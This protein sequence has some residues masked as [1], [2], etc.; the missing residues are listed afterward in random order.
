MST[1]RLQISR[2]LQSSRRSR[3]PYQV[4]KQGMAVRRAV[5][6]S[7]GLSPHPSRR[8]LPFPTRST[9]LP[10]NS[11]A[12][13]AFAS[14]PDARASVL[15]VPERLSK[16]STTPTTPS[17]TLN[18]FQRP[19]PSHCRPPQY[20]ATVAIVEATHCRPPSSGVGFY[21]PPDEPSAPCMSRATLDELSVP[22]HELSV[23][24]APDCCPRS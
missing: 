13:H 19:R 6:P 15:D 24:S 17:T 20:L 12:S 11:I 10:T 9:V 8:L 18:A 3:P 2:R 21:L 23:L 22:L 4:L 1:R 16:F 7:Q 14:A 5:A